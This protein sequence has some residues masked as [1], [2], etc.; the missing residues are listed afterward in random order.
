VE[1][2]TISTGTNFVNHG[3][4]QINEDAARNVFTSAGF[5]KK[6]VERIVATANGFIRGHLAV[7]LNAVFQA[8]KFP[9]RIPD[10]N[11]GLANMD[12]NYFTH[13]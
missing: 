4:F 7:R 1:Q 11:A 12:R 3:W 10:L 2:L 6:G 13:I 5:R 9:A 8:V